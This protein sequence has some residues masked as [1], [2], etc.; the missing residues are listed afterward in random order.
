MQVEF[1]VIEPASGR[2]IARAECGYNMADTMKI[3]LR[4]IFYRVDFEITD[5]RE[6][7]EGRNKAAAWLEREREIRR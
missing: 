1:E 5:S 7:I 6:T 4:R 3:G 2:T